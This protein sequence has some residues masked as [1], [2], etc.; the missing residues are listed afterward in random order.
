MICSCAR[1]TRAL[2]RNEKPAPTDYVGI[3]GV[4]EDA[5][6][7]PKESP[8]A[9]FFGYQRHLYIDRRVG[10]NDLPAGTSH[11]MV[12]AETTRDNGPW[13]A[14]NRSTVRPLSPEDL[15][16]IGLQRQF[17]G[18]HP[19]GANLLKVD[20]SVQFFSSAATQTCSPTSPCWARPTGDR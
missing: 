5:A 3:A 6:F 12:C 8:R 16:Y 4:G 10:T 17:G 7:L 14:A 13:V 1:R 11:T 20:A 2:N 15:P 9:G 18:C 19:G